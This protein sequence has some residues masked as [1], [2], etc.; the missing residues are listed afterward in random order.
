MTV[1]G[2]TITVEPITAPE[3]SAMN[4]GAVVSGVDIENLTGE[5]SI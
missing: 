5:S 2:K 3:G 4:F 1:T